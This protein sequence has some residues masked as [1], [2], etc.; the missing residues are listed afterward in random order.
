MVDPCGQRTTH[1][2]GARASTNLASSSRAG[3]RRR[4]VEETQ[5][6]AE[7]AEAGQMEKKEK[8]KQNKQCSENT[9]R[10][11]L[12][13]PGNAKATATA[14]SATATTTTTG[15]L[16]QACFFFASLVEEWTSAGSPWLHALLEPRSGGNCDDC[17]LLFGMSSSRSQLP[18]RL[19]FTTQPTKRPGNSTTPHG[20]RR[21]QAP[22]TTSFRT[23][24][25]CLRGVPGHPVWV[26][27]GGHRT[28]IS[29]ALWSRLP[30]TPLCYRF[31]IL[32]S[33]GM[34][35]CRVSF[36]SFSRVVR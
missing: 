34:Y 31:W 6:F 30:I 4:Q 8:E 18:R 19:H 15:C 12:H 22:S 7:E 35:R 3:S 25:R 21:T 17:E 27:R 23:K 32:W 33:R 2:D 5:N 1:A 9:P 28:G 29:C 24:M 26:S 36:D 10:V 14:T 13:F 20:D 16:S 11:V